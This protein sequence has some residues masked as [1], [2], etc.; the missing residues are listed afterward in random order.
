MPVHSLVIRAVLIIATTELALML[1]LHWLDL[2]SF[3]ETFWDTS[4][5][6]VLSAA[7]L[8]FFI[9]RRAIHE[10]MLRY[11]EDLR[12]RDSLSAALNKI[13]RLSLQDLPLPK[14]LELALDELLSVPWLTLESKGG[15][16]LVEGDSR[17]LTMKAQRKLGVAVEAMC[18]QVPFGKCLCGMAAQSGK[19]VH[20]ADLD[21]RHEHR[22]QG[23][24]PHGHYCVPI[25]H[26]WRVAGVMVLYL[27]PGNELDF[28][29]VAF[30]ESVADV[31]SIIVGHHQMD[32]MLAALKDIP[33]KAGALADA[34]DILAATA[35]GICETAGWAVGEVWAP[36]S[37]EVLARRYSWHLPEERF[38]AF[39]AASGGFQ[40][41]PGEGLPGRVWATLAPAWIEDVTTDSNFPRRDQARRAGLKSALAVPVLSQGQLVAVLDFFKT[42]LSPANRRLVDF[43]AVVAGRIGEVLRGRELAEQLLHS[44][45]LD[46]IGR[47]AGGVA[48]DFNNLLTAI[49]GYGEFVMSGLRP[50]DPLRGDV[51]E[52][53]A[54]AQR[55]A[56]L[57]RQLLAF[58][59]K[60][61][62]LPCVLDLNESVSSL[63]KML[64][65]LL[66]EA[67]EL[68]LELS[69]EA[70]RVKADAGQLEQVVVN[71][72][73]NAR[74]AMPKG[75][76]LLM[77]TGS[78][79]LAGE[80]AARAELGPGRYALLS[81]ADTGTGMSREV[82]ARIFEPFFTTKEQGQG[83]GLGLATVYGIV[84][85]SGGGIAVESEPG[86][87]SEF[88]IYLPWAQEER[89]EETAPAETASA[90]GR[91]VVLL[92]EDEEQVRAL[93]ARS[94]REAGFEVH[95]ASGADAAIA[96]VKAGCR[97][98]LLLTDVVLPGL[99]GKDL[100]REVA[101]LRPGVKILFMSGF[102]QSAAAGP[103][104][105][106]GDDLLQKPFTPDQ[107][108]RR[109]V[110][111]LAG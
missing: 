92:V 100:A 27:R 77:R 43:V 21:E 47:L 89:K 32:R 111:A 25:K 74:D 59:R 38:G 65:R 52:I 24:S 58:S 17:T 42:D 36:V 46:A 98:E 95:E 103:A 90:R 20:A 57:T 104:L 71:L 78:V 4:L 45:K 85:Q 81:V 61:R 102:S 14:L 2:S 26:E 30:L 6:A 93:A 106:A 96:Q 79:E 11:L 13:L 108:A 51:A 54:A 37:G 8:Y 99:G 110:Q 18:A 39:A 16:F 83:T 35:R 84:K 75:G 33:L 41:R 1:A 34:E 31:L 12:R 28:Q 69:P 91:G 53:R 55:A 19:L 60:Q 3:W 72:A 76:R 50:E 7:G 29:E 70:C 80:E 88:R 86:R 62:L 9:I 49:L 22:Y 44:Q 82:R 66:G 15:I 73:V 97:P 48:H 68:A 10:N 107:L 109:V 23:I 101:A 56:A 40:F 67:V 105:G 5:L 87:G 94:L 64:R 63:A